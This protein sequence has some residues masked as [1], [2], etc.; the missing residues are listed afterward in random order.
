MEATV[1]SA[2][3]AQTHVQ[4]L[5]TLYAFWCYGGVMHMK[6]RPLSNVLMLNRS[7]MGKLLLFC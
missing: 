7:P 4:Q 3:T 2:D 6:L 5:F 1:C